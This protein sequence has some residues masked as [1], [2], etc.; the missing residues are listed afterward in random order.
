MNSAYDLRKSQGNQIN[1]TK[2]SGPCL[3]ER[4]LNHIG[5]GLG[6]LQ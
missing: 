2:F 6:L 4:K 3:M 1:K 5:H